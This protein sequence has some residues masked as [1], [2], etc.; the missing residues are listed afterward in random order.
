MHVKCIRENP[1]SPLCCRLGVAFLA[2]PLTG[3]TPN[4]CDARS[5]V[6][7]G[8][9][10]KPTTTESFVGSCCLIPLEP[11]AHRRGDREHSRDDVRARSASSSRSASSARARSHRGAQGTA[12]SLTLPR[13]RGRGKIINWSG[14]ATGAAFSFVHFFWPEVAPAHPCARDIRASLHS[15]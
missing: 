1:A 8:P 7:R 4:A 10:K 14:A 5:R 13:K 11:A 2:T 15:T 9:N 12:P 3:F 6:I